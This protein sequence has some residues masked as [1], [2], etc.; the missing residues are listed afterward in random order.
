MNT[1]QQIFRDVRLPADLK[2][3]LSR[4]EILRAGGGTLLVLGIWPGILGAAEESP[5]QDFSFVVVNDVHYIDEKCGAWLLTVMAKMK[6]CT[7]KPELCLMLGDY[8]DHGTLTELAAVRDIFKQLGIP[9]Y[10]IIGNHDWLTSNDRKPYEEVFPGRIN[11]R[12]D[13]RG[14]QFMALD[15]TDG[16]KPSATSISAD[17]LR[18]VDDNLPKLDKKKPLILMSHFPLGPKINFRPVN[19]DTLLQRFKEYNLR[20]VFSG[21]FHS[22]TEVKLAETVFT[23]GKCCSLKR[24]NHDQ[25]RE[26]GFYFCQIKNSEIIR[27]FIEVQLP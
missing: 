21:H 27:T 14:W 5:S 25:T 26:R 15:T 7:P 23:T 22:F 1:I 16:L 19:A 18:W 24:A 12:F 2:S 3:G 9:T 4:R 10:G 17:T 6:A 11:Y 20:A 13:H 8:T